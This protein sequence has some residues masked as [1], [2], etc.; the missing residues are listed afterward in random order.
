VLGNDRLVARD[1]QLVRVETST[2]LRRA[3]L[4]RALTR[5][6][7]VVAPEGTPASIVVR[8]SDDPPTNAPVELSVSGE[9]IHLRI[10][11][12]IDATAWTSLGRVVHELMT[13]TESGPPT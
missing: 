3:G 11:S 7:L 8:T 9:G 5:A 12:E 10:R 1:S 6:G 2:A 4:E 13:T